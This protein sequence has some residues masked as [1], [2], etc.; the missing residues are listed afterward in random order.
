MASVASTL[1]GGSIACMPMPISMMT[2]PA[3]YRVSAES[4]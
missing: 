1:V 3:L 4:M 2:A